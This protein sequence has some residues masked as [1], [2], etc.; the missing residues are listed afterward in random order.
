VIS[1]A[2]DQ[3]LAIGAQGFSVQSAHGRDVPG[4]LRASRPIEL[5]LGIEGERAVLLVDDGG[6]GIPPEELDRVFQRFARSIAVAN[7]SGIGLGL[8]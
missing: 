2:Y 5:K 7:I 4:P 1:A 3:A 8:H 6:I